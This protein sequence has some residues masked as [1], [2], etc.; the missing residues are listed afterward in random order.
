ME[1]HFKPLSKSCAATGAPLQ[2]GSW[3]HSVVVERNG[4]QQR[5]DYS[6]AGWKGPPDDAI[7]HWRSQV[8]ALK[9]SQAIRIDPD[10]L[11]RYFEQLSEEASPSQ[12]SQ[13]YVAALVLLKQRRLR[14]DNV[15]TDAEGPT[16]L[17]LEGTHGEGLFQVTDL[18]LNDEDA[19]RWQNELKQ[20]LT[21]EWTA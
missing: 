13:R 2:P 16:Q 14:L 7:G 9:S 6:E 12:E 11:M 19:A 1:Y 5:L 10:A 8:P 3:C 15:Q 17:I 18:Q 20:H 21:T 4:Q